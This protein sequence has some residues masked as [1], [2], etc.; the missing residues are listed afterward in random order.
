MS[1]SPSHKVSVRVLIV[2]DPL[3]DALWLEKRKWR[4]FMDTWLVVPDRVLSPSPRV[5]VSAE[6]APLLIT[7]PI[8]AQMDGMRVA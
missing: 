6:I 7:H 4:R 2:S 1:R 5:V 3:H 8:I